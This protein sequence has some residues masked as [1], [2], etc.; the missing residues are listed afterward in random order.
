MAAYYPPVGFHFEVHFFGIGGEDDSQFQEVSGLTAE[1]GVEELQVGGEN[2]FTY[3]LPTR[4]KYNNLVLKRGMLKDSALID[5]FRNAIENFE[6]KPADLSIHLLDE[7]H[8]VLT[9]WD[10]IQAYPV[11]WSISDFKALENSLVVET[12]ELAYQYFKRKK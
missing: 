6:F 3:R 12:I 2:K 4:A 1:I 7:N 8:Q 11:K 9:S 5:W 10:F